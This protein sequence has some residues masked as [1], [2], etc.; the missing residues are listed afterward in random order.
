MQTLTWI[1]PV[2]RLS[3]LIPVLFKFPHYCPRIINCPLQINGPAPFVGTSL[4]YS[5][6]HYRDHFINKLSLSVVEAQL[7]YELKIAESSDDKCTCHRWIKIL[8]QA[9]C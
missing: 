9:F 1:E 4:P 6:I 2:L 7:I 8:K 3:G 5:I